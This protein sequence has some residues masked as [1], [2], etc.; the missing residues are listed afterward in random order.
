M[1]EG[2]LN[3]LAHRPLANMCHV[4]E[5]V[6]TFSC[7]TPRKI[8]GNVFRKLLNATSFFNVFGMTGSSTNRY[9]VCR[10]QDPAPIDILFVVVV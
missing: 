3:C 5:L 10:G 9:F 2:T 6:S 7:K 4:D 1:G 8:M